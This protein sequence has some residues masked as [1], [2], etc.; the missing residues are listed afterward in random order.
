MS[1]CASHQIIIVR[2]V[3]ATD[4]VDYDCLIGLGKLKYIKGDLHAA[5]DLFDR[6]LV[7]RLLYH[8]IYA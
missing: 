3:L 7:V 1:R 8:T 2:Q 4:P 5:R 6:A